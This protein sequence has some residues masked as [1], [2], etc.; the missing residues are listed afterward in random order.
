M[1]KGV[2][3]IIH[4]KKKSKSWKQKNLDFFSG[5]KFFCDDV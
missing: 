5:G 3:M 1:G 4:L 2:R